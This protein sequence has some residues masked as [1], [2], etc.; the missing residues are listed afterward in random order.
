MDRSK[1]LGEDKVSKLLIRFSIP[2]IVG[3]L[4]NALYNVVDRI[5]IGHGVGYLGIG[6]T[7]IAFPIMLIMMAFS[8]LIGLGA[9]SL[10]AI[11][12]GQNRKEE[13]QG[14]FGNALVLL[15]LTSLVLSTTGLIFLKPF[16]KLLGTSEDILP[17]A[18]DYLSII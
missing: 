18:L 10:V 12:L 17:Y 13:A 7:T 5:Y 9:N 2:A 6:A 3:M 1:Q 15:I 14:I 16:L 8:M 11:R 4:V